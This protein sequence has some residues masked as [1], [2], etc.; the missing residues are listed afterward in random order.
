M[1]KFS[2]LC[3]VPSQRNYLRLQELTLSQYELILKF[4][5]NND[6][7]GL[8][9]CFEEIIRQNLLEDVNLNKFHKWFILV[10]LR[11][12]CISPVSVYEIK[13]NENK[14]AILDVSILEMLEK[15]SDKNL[16]EKIY[17]DMNDI[18]LGFTVPCALDSKDIIFESLK[19][20]VIKNEESVIN[21]KEKD[22]IIKKMSNNLKYIIKTN[23]SKEYDDSNFKLIGKL[24]EFNIKGPSF[25]LTDNTLFDHLIKLYSLWLN[26]LHEKKYILINKI[27]FGLRDIISMT[28]LECEVYINHYKQ[29]Q[30]AFSK[31]LKTPSL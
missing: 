1:K 16:K 23:L 6:N 17:I 7:E 28:P 13:T 22:I 9:D 20:V 30:K 10:F 25:K 24:D 19:T 18:K 11:S 27:G 29:E 12:I 3:W 21:D 8:E 15:I 5:L 14:P 31:K 4:I 2:L 26:V